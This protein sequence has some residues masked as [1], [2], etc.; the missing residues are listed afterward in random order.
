MFCLHRN[1]TLTLNNQKEEKGKLW[2]VHLRNHEEGFVTV[3]TLGSFALKSLSIN[4][5]KIVFLYNSFPDYAIEHSNHIEVSPG[6]C[7]FVISIFFI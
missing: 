1:L 7:T 5:S 2:I 6:F 4:I 3:I